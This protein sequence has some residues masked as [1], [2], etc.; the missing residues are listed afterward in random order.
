MRKRICFALCCVFCAFIM[1]GCGQTEGAQ[2]QDDMLLY[3]FESYNEIVSIA[4]KRF[5]GSLDVSGDE[6]Y[7]TEGENALRWDIRSSFYGG[8]VSATQGTYATPTLTIY[9]GNFFRDVSDFS[10]VSAYSLD[11]SNANDFAV[12]MIFWAESG[13]SMIAVAHREVLPGKTQ[14]IDLPVNVVATD[15]ITRVSSLSIALYDSVFDR[16]ATVYLD[17]LRVYKHR[18]AAA[19][20][21]VAQSGTVVGMDTVGILQYVTA[22]NSTPLPMVAVDYNV[23]PRF[24]NG[25]NGSVEISVLPCSDGSH[26]ISND[27]YGAL[28][29][30]GVSLL[31]QLTE[32]IDFSVVNFITDGKILLDVYNDNAESVYAYLTITD[33][34]GAVQWQKTLLGANKWTTVSLSQFGNVDLSNIVGIDLLFDMYSF[35]NPMRFFCNNLAVGA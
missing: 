29:R 15:G 7:V 18:A 6:K 24:T 28:Q 4:P 31:R 16:E 30:S 19:N 34:N 33:A 20:I 14:T 10:D 26:M 3:G 32:R 35:G 1:G 27:Y 22:K 2:E 21:A 17:N 8:V 9:A 13:G 25:K 23:L 12:S 5:L 11:V